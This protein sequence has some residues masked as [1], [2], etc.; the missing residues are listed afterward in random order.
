MILANNKEVK[1]VA[2]DFDGT[3]D[4]TDTYPNISQPNIDLI[5]LLI[6]QKKNGVKLILWTCREDKYL[7]EAVE[8]CSHY[9]LE[10]DAVNRNIPEVIKFFGHNGTKVS[11]DV[12]I[13]EKTIL[14]E[15]YLSAFQY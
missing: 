14:P 6:N 12:Y 1:V 2:V 9:G 15:K 7:F 3:L 11:A 10:F 8:W 13:D 5:N 4:M